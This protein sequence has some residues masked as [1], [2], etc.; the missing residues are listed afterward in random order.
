P[1]VAYKSPPSH[2]LLPPSPLPPSV[3]LHRRYG[4]SIP[5]LHSSDS[6][7]VLCCS[8]IHTSASVP[9]PFVPPWPSALCLCL[10]TIGQLPGVVGPTSSM[11]RHNGCGLGPTWLLL[12]KVPP[13]SVWSALVSPVVSLVPSSIW[14][15]LVA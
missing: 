11:G 14:S 15:A 5:C 2:P 8:R 9:E 1:E 4:W 12:L 13:V 6:T 10:V 7:L 3:R